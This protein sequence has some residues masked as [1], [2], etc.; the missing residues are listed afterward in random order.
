MYFYN[1]LVFVSCVSAFIPLNILK[2][3]TRLRMSNTNSND[4]NVTMV[5]FGDLESLVPLIDNDVLKQLNYN[6]PGIVNE[7]KDIVEDSF[8]GY[9]RSHF[10][11]LD[12]K[13]ETIDFETFYTW[14]C[15]VG[16]LLNK[17]EVSEIYNF[18][19]EDRCNLIN[20]IMINK[21]IDEQDGALF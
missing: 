12:L 15:S 9:L 7:E 8:E 11:K 4:K 6:V 1:I 20:F 13:N 5:E 3:Q 21:I 18:V 16:T 17:E 10:R 14:R 2:C 19:V